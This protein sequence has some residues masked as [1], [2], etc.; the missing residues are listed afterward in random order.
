M[1]K[2]QKRR[3]KKRTL[4]RITKK[5]RLQVYKKYGGC[6][7]YCGEHLNYR[8]MQVDHIV[9]YHRFRL[10]A[11]DKETVNGFGNLNPSCRSCNFYKGAKGI[12]AFR[13]LM[14]GLIYRLK[15]LFVIRIALKYKIIKI[16]QWDGLFYYEKHQ[17]KIKNHDENREN[18]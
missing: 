9:S 8:E 11:L 18:R 12:E 5:Q 10:G 2:K 1:S 4:P 16:N 3:K 17:R 15:K 6:C 14:D 7:A 13:S